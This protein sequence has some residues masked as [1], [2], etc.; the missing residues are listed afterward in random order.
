MTTEP[1]SI[2]VVR[3]SR[4]GHQFHEAWAARIA[5]E[6]LPPDTSL[7]AIAIEGF[8]VED[9]AEVSDAAHEIADLVRYRGGQTLATASRIETLQFKYSIT[10]A[11]RPMR[12]SE[13]AKTLRKFASA[14]AD[15]TKARPDANDLAHFELVTNRPIDA[16]TLAALAALRAGD[17]LDGRAADHARQI[18]GATDLTGAALQAFANKLTLTGAGGALV[19][20]E[21]TNLR[22]LASWSG[23]TDNLSHARLANLRRLVR[24]RAGSQGQGDNRIGRVDVLGALDIAHER[25]IYPVRAAFPDVEA[26]IERPVLDEIIDLVFADPRALLIH[27]AGGVGKTVLMQALADKLSANHCVL[28]FDGFGAGMW[29]EPSDGRHLP[30]KSLPHLANLLAANGLCD[31]M[32]QSSHVEESLAALRERLAASVATLR[33]F[34]A[35]ANVILVLDAIDHCGMQ[36]KRTGTASFGHILLQS[37]NIASIAGVRVVASCRTHRRYEAQLDARCREFA[38]P[39]F[40]REETAALVQ[41]R[42]PS[43]TSNDVTVL[44]RRSNGNPRLLDNLLRR[45][46]PFDVARPGQSSETLEQLLREQIEAAEEQAIDRGATA[47]EARGLLAGMAMLPPPVPVDELASALGLSQSDVESFVTDLFPLIELTPTGLIFRDEPTET[48]VVKMI[49][50]DATAR[51]DLLARLDAR[52]A[53]SIYAARALPGILAE[54]AEVD[55]LVS[56][57]FDA[58]A[59]PNLSRVAH[60][61]IR[62]ARLSAAISACAAADRVDDLTKLTLEAARISS[63]TECSD[64]Y[65]RAHP[66][67]VA[68][69]GDAE[70]IRRFR[71]DRSTWAGRRHAS[72]A[73][74]DSFSGDQHAAALESDRALTWFDWS[75][76]EKREGRGSD[77]RDW[78]SLEADAIFVQLLRGN[79][80][81][82]DHWLAK[83]DDRYA[84]GIAAKMLGYADRLARLD[85]SGEP[86]RQVVQGL[87]LCR[88]RSPAVVAA[89]AARLA[90]DP[91]VR[92][93]LYRRLANVKAEPAELGSY[94]DYRQED[95]LTDG[96]LDAAGQAVALGL[97]R[98]AQKIIAHAASPGLRAYQLDDPWPLSGS[99]VAQHLKF[100]AIF[101]AAKRRGTHVTDLLPRDMAEFVPLAVRRRGPVAFERNLRLRLQAARNE[102]KKHPGKR[103]IDAEEARRWEQCLAKRLSPLPQFVDQI[104]AILKSPDPAPAI[105]KALSDATAAIASAETYP[106]RDQPRFLARLYLDVIRWAAACRAPLD[107][108]SGVGLAAFLEASETQVVAD[109]IGMIALLARMPATQASAL[110]LARLAEPIIRADTDVSAQIQGYGSLARALLPISVE[111]ARPYFRIGLELADAVGSDDQ[112][113]IGDLIEFAAQYSGEPLSPEIAHAFVRLVELNIPNEAEALNWRRFTT[114]LTNIAGPAGLAPLARM[115]DREKIGLGWTLPP[116]LKALVERDRLTPTLAASLVGVAQ[117]EATWN[118]FPPHVAQAILPRLANPAR[119]RFAQALLV[120]LDRDDGATLRSEVLH[121]YKRLFD[122]ELPSGS[123]VRAR[124]DA[125]AAAK[126]RRSILPETT[127]SERAAPMPTFLR[128]V[129]TVTA[130]AL[131]A[132]IDKAAATFIGNRPT[133]GFILKSFVPPTTDPSPRMALLNAV[134]DDDLLRFQDKVWFL[135][136]AREHWHGASRALDEALD[137]AAIRVALRHLDDVVRSGDS[138]RRPL[139]RIAHLAGTQRDE[140]VRGVL[141]ALPGQDV[142]ISSD[143]WMGCAILLAKSASAQAIGDALA[144]YTAQSTA[145]FPDSIGDGPYSSAFAVDADV[146]AVVGD[147]LWM[148][149]GSPDA[150]DRWRAAHAVRTLCAGGEYQILVHLLSGLER[151]SAGAFQDQSRPFF[152]LHARTWLLIAVARIAEEAPAGVAPHRATIEALA[153]SDAFPHVLCR[154]FAIAALRALAASGHVANAAS[155]VA[156]LDTLNRPVLPPQ[157][158]TSHRPGFYSA[159]P[160]D[161]PEPQPRFRFDYDFDKYQVDPLGGVFGLAKWEVADT[162]IAWIRR[163]DTTVE[164]MYDGPRGRWSRDDMSYGSSTFPPADLHGGQLAWHA[165]LL[166]AG[167]LARERPVSGETWER[168]PWESWLWE[169]LLSREDGRWLSDGTD[170]FPVEVAQPVLRSKSNASDQVLVPPHPLDLLTL[171][172]FDDTLITPKCFLVSA[173]WESCDGLDV[174]I[175]SQLVDRRR[176]RAVAHA[177]Y[178]ADP[179]FA[180]LPTDDGGE[181]AHDRRDPSERALLTRWLSGDEH[182]YTKLDSRDPYGFATALQR[183]RPSAATVTKMGLQQADPFA[184]SWIDPEGKAIFNAAAW[185]M[186]SGRGRHETERGGTRLSVD[187]DALTAMLKAQDQAL[188][189]LIKVRRYVEKDPK[190]DHFR[191][192]MLAVI[193]QPE[194]PLELV[195]AVPPCLRAAIAKLGHYERGEFADRFAAVEAL[196]TPRR[197]SWPRSRARGAKPLAGT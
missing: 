58:R 101:A 23:A 46:A 29:R 34:D 164:S 10:A 21:H 90:L 13:M 35:N 167:Q 180:Y 154:H 152:H 146:H 130:G 110:R 45:G 49:G 122:S 37:L 123:P 160:E 1:A 131:R 26:Q 54:A 22:T 94:H 148:R 76:R 104:V 93:T 126:T 18:A 96:L 9:A 12:A 43:A 61:A 172:G 175:G 44:Q 108:A 139:T 65:L 151:N 120:E 190:D 174:T 181:D 15:L 184:R 47:S 191:H 27:A 155:Y 66:D 138:W 89:I 75:L 60:R 179:F 40:S 79:A 109:W 4:D 80:V 20:V 6:L 103:P 51:T 82:I 8:A 132:A 53:H 133:D 11:D 71:D 85:N 168:A 119:E 158:R 171:A 19:R 41:K 156:W 145:S 112:E 84:F 50:A 62:L 116:M 117:F 39:T 97:I 183:A 176:A 52:Q 31:I 87:K 142:D 127:A 86:A 159:R 55:A 147:L 192:Q 193:V 195:F 32:L 115:A 72:L 177:V 67:L 48:L 30:R 182:S 141:K 169:R 81:R 77:R 163:Y 73:V 70:A 197:Q 185:G 118:W 186:R 92:R 91:Q 157:P 28:L 137:G 74:L 165:V 24:D 153:A 33:Q 56:L 194:E 125:F 134:A 36:A 111:E 99:Q 149:L 69:S 57:A 173:S 88:S 7:A 161:R 2:D 5:L 140:L 42:F 166:A 124:I 162:A 187:R 107:Q 105:A 78:G 121:Q 59:M 38:V 102:R 25:E 136:S 113:R 100:A 144:H 16:D 3:A 189:M 17:N 128:G 98:D 68:L 178:S 63:A 188:L 129:T 196:G 143:F 83:L 64:A 14:A 95:R 170:L 135:E 106:Y 114:A 150:G